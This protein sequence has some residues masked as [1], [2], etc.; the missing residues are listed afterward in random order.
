[1]P[2]RPAKRHNCPVSLNLKTMS[3][4]ELHT[5]PRHSLILLALTRN[6]VTTGTKTRN[7]NTTSGEFQDGGLSQ[8]QLV[9]SLTQRL[10]KVPWASQSTNLP[11]SLHTRAHWRRCR[12]RSAPRLANVST[13]ILKTCSRITCTHTPPMPHHR[14]TLHSALTLMMATR[15]PWSVLNVENAFLRSTL[16]LYPHLAPDLL[17]YQDQICKLCSRK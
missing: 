8:P 10:F 4:A 13:S 7:S 3:L 15:Y 14:T 11:C 6:L 16:S 2:P 12:K 17:A 9:P 5:L 1:M